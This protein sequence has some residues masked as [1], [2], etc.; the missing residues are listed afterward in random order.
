LKRAVIKLNDGLSGEGNSVFDFDVEQDGNSEQ[1]LETFIRS[2]LPRRIRFEAVT[3]TWEAYIQKFKEMGGIV[4]CWIE[5]QEKRSPSVQCRID[6]IGNVNVFSTHDQVLGGPTGQ[7]YLGCSFPADEAYCLEIQ[8]AGQRIG[9]LMKEKGVLNLFGIDFISV[10][11]DSRWKHYAIEINLRKGGTTFPY[12]VLQFLTDGQY[13]QETGLFRLLNGE[14]RYYYAS[15]NFQK[16]RYKGLTPDDLIDTMVYN[17][18]HF[19]SASQQG[20]VFH[21]M[22]AVSE[23]GKFGVTCIGEHPEQARVLYDTTMSA[24]DRETGELNKESL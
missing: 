17:Q 23:F 22:G 10:K 1:E 20:V 15:D 7:I 8:E 14:P 13:D 4:E 12:L 6:P 19:D 3:E 5:G 16:A 9:T 24:L 11:S 2:E 18:L 21:L